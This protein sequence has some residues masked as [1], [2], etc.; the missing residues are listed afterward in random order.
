MQRIA[1]HAAW[2]INATPGRKKAVSVKQLLGK[3][4]RMNRDDKEAEFKKLM[5]LMKGS[6]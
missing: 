1:I 6:R 4:R 5:E 3:E 2:I